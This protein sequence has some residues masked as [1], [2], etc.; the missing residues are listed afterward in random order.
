MLFPRPYPDELVGSLLIR[1][2]HHLGLQPRQLAKIIGVAPLTSANF[3]VPSGL[4]RIATLTAT[5]VEELLTRHTLFPYLC[6][7]LEN[8][9]VDGLRA[10]VFAM[11]PP[12]YP[13][14]RACFA[15]RRC[16]TTVR[17]Y[18][19]ACVDA[20]TKAYGEC[21]WHRTHVIP[22]V[23]TCPTH[24]CNLLCSDI[25]IL[26]NLGQAANRLPYEVAGTNVDWQASTSDLRRLTTAAAH[27]VFLEPG[28]WSN[29]TDLYPAV[30][31]KM[32]YEDLKARGVRRA[33]AFDLEKAIGQQ[34]LAKLGLSPRP[35]AMT[36]WPIN[37][38]QGVEPLMQAPFVHLL[39]RR[40][41][42]LA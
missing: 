18:C 37:L 9:L 34:F 21:Y 20:D 2:S 29:W 1:A 40:F 10:Q 4:L 26:E 14:F 32:G 38:A 8:E 36:G 19:P 39:F 17:R 7:T 11:G 35:H 31:R 41:L 15:A 6:L 28:A 12:V 33:L 25:Q 42:G 23:L 30:L 22:G 5:P 27:T 13:H 3:I 16:F 24:H